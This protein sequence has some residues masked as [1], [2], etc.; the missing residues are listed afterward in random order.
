MN[1]ISSKITSALEGKIKEVEPQLRAAV[2]TELSKLV[3][4]MKA[5]VVGTK[6]RIE[7][8]DGG[9]FVGEVNELGDKDGYGVIHWASGSKYSGM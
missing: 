2:D 9:K 6:K 8:E 3:D 1:W 5:R 4:Q 7:Y